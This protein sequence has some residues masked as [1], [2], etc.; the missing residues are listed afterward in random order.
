M[1]SNDVT[2]FYSCTLQQI[3]TNWKIK[4]FIT[5]ERVWLSPPNFAHHHFR[6]RPFISNHCQFSKTS[7]C[8]SIMQFPAANKNSDYLS[9]TIRIIVY[10][11]LSRNEIFWYGSLQE[12]Y[13]SLQ[14]NELFMVSCWNYGW[15]LEL[16]FSTGKI[17]VYCG[18]FVKNMVICRNNGLTQESWFSAGIKS[19]V[20]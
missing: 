11:V 18:N 7:C 17:M 9:T 13:G 3:L 6:K 14:E 5:S 20:N 19:Y 1:F 8:A 10:M 12:N 16:W 4:I 2:I 15:L